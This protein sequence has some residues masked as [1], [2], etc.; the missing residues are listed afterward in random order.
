MWKLPG[1]GQV[2]SACRRLP[3]DSWQGPRQA[4][5][6]THPADHLTTAKTD[7]TTPLDQPEDR[8]LTVSTSPTVCFLFLLGRKEK[9][10]TGASPLATH[11]GLTS[12]ELAL[13]RTL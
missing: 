13:T 1:Y 2:L 11:G 8:L 6:V 3:M 10:A 4:S 5:P 7:L 12:P 9:R